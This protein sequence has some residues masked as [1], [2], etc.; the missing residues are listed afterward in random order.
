[1]LLA[2]LWLLHS[3][4]ETLGYSR[5]A[6]LICANMFVCPY[7]GGDFNN[8]YYLM[9]FDC[10]LCEAQ[11]YGGRILVILMLIKLA[12][13]CERGKERKIYIFLTELLVFWVALSAGLY[14]IVTIIAPLLLY[15]V[16]K[17]FVYG[18]YSFAYNKNKHLFWLIVAFVLT[19][20]GRYV[21]ARYLGFSSNEGD[22]NLIGVNEFWYN[23]GT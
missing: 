11:F 19:L 3:I 16:W 21:Q 10:V 4:M 18:E 8:A 1:M 15:C 22:I 2:M 12:L 9:W 17:M 5:T 23:L 6:Q 14:M 13:D 20:I 7:L